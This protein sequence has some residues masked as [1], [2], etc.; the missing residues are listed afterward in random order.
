MNN[1]PANGFMICLGEALNKPWTDDLLGQNQDSGTCEFLVTL[2]KIMLTLA[3]SLIEAQ[4]RLMRF[5][6]FCKDMHLR[7]K[8][9]AKLYQLLRSHF[10]SLMRLLKRLT[11]AFPTTASM[12]VT[13]AQE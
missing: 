8:V 9:R 4:Q 6:S 2:I 3:S 12:A 13:A 5:I 11:F 1:M 10:Q 7:Q